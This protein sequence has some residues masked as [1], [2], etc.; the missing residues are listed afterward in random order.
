MNC[1]KK[2]LA[3][4]HPIYRPFCRRASAAVLSA[5]IQDGTYPNPAYAAVIF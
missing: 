5:D 4:P 2:I 3:H 1:V